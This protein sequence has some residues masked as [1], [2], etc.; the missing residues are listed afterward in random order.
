MI[1]EG[2]L[3][4]IFFISYLTS[5]KEFVLVK[6]FGANLDKVCHDNPGSAAPFQSIKTYKISEILQ[7]FTRK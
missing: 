1:L 7:V 6:I 4:T 3:N 5:Q 2:F